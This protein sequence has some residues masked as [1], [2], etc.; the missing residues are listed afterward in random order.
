MSNEYFLARYEREQEA[1]GKLRLA[2]Y[3]AGKKGWATRRRN[4]KRGK[5]PRTNSGA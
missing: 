5:K 1:A 2:R 3:L 4:A